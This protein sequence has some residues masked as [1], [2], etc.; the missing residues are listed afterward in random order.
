MDNNKE[1]SK[2]GILS[3]KSNFQKKLNSNDGLRPHF[4]LCQ[5]IYRKRFSNEQYGSEI[6]RRR[7]YRVDNK[8]NK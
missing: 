5:K 1:C 8:K 7:K 2:C 6:N 3:L 4:K